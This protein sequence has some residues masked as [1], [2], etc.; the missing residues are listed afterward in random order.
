M[1]PLA[2]QE[3]LRRR[4]EQPPSSAG[5]GAEAANSLSP[6]NPIASGGPELMTNPTTPSMEGGASGMPSDGT[7]AGMKQQKSESQT[8]IDALIWRLKRIT[9]TQG[10][11]VIA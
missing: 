11:P 4:A 7:I 8:L 5:I 3:A 10:S 2:M 6:E 9:P 1:D